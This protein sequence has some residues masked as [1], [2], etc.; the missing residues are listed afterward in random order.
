MKNKIHFYS[1]KSVSD[2]YSPKPAVEN[3]PEWYKKTSS[4]TDDNKRPFL[5]G[6]QTRSTIKKC[7]PVFD[8]ISMGYFIFLPYDIYIEYDGFEYNFVIPH[9]SAEVY[10]HGLGQVGIHPYVTGDNASVPKFSNPWSIKTPN[11]YSC[12]I[13]P[14]MHRDNIIQIF[15]GVVDTD[16]YDDYINLPF[17]VSKKEFT[18][19]VPAGT[20][21]AQVIPFKRE[22]WK[23]ENKIS[24]GA[25]ESGKLVRSVFFEGYKKLFWSRKE[26][27]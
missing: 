13:I 5:D 15:P 2:K 4:Y 16:T 22:S 20:P 6:N 24:E 12:L 19:I 9:K 8:S 23:I 25:K 18:G 3:L 11:G 10:I 26:Y 27:K 17:V 1:D 14:P 7:I 21:I